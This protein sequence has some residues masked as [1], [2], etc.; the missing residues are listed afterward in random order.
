MNEA[1]DARGISDQTGGGHRAGNARSKAWA[2]AVNTGNIT[3]VA[4]EINW[5]CRLMYNIQNWICPNMSTLSSII[6]DSGLTL[7]QIHRRSGVSRTTLSRITNGRQALS[8]RTAEKLAPVLGVSAEE[9]IKARS[10]RPAAPEILRISA[11][12]LSLWGKTRRAEEELP[13]LVSRLIRSELFAFGFI[14]APSDERI[15]EPGADIAVTAPRS[16]RHIPEGPSVWEVS[17][18]KNVQ[19]KAKGDLKRYK[20]PAGW[21]PEKTS[22]VFVTTE[23]W[24]G[25]NE[26]AF[27]QRAEHRWRSH[28][29]SRGIRPA[30]LDRGIT[31]CPAL[32]D[33]PDGGQSQRIPMAV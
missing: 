18:A 11:L 8:R 10:T 6:R 19:G 3:A 2:R 30:E 29:R 14:R 27:Q 28:K 32:A 33:G 12:Q 17:T 16:T 25:A 7:S 5:L 26:W 24:T 15:I 21:Q 22:F 20:V 13:E 1:V 31:R 9:M 4:S 23:S